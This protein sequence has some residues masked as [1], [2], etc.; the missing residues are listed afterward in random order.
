MQFPYET[1]AAK[2]SKQAHHLSSELSQIQVKQSWAGGA[3]GVAQERI[4]NFLL[5]ANTIIVHFVDVM[6]TSSLPNMM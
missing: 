6:K 2:Y 1:M 3:T 4:N 5:D